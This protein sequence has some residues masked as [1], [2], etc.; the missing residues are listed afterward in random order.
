MK[1]WRMVFGWTYLFLGIVL[2]LLNSAF[3]ITGA[4]ILEGFSDRYFS[5]LGL[6]FIALGFVITSFTESEEYESRESKLKNMI[7]E[8]KY[9]RLSEYEKH[10]YNKAYRRS[11]EKRNI[12]GRQGHSELEKKSDFEIIRTKHFERAV[13]NYDPDLI[14]KAIEKIGTGKGREKKLKKD[15]GYSV[16][17]SKGDRL[18]FRREGNKIVLT[19]YVV[20]HKALD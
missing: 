6:I 2:F 17:T 1:R 13:R 15:I 3:N 14:Q 19:D 12:G 7:G 9:D 16:R 11:M 18:V 5:I 8:R 4:V 10:A 20:D